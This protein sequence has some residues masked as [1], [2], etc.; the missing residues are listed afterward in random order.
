M[1]LTSSELASREVLCRADLYDFVSLACK[2]QVF[3]RTDEVNLAGNSST[4]MQLPQSA[5]QMV[6]GI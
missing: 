3:G 1:K 5:E 6:T 4:S 2:E